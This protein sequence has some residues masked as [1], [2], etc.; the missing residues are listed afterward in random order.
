VVQVQALDLVTCTS[1][2]TVP[3]RALGRRVSWFLKPRRRTDF[4]VTLAQ[5]S[6]FTLGLHQD[7][8]RCLTTA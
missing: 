7:R 4:G 2:S 5:Q 8:A 1:C 3:S 6:E